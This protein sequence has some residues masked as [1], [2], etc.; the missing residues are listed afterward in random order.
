MSHMVLYKKGPS[1]KNYSSGLSKMS[2]W[3]GEETRC[4]TIVPP[5]QT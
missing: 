2:M 4:A 1:V 3:P 5:R